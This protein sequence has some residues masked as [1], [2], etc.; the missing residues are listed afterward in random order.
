MLSYVLPAFVR[1][2]L[3]FIWVAV[4]SVLCASSAIVCGLLKYFFP[5][6]PWM[7]L[8]TRLMSALIIF[9]GDCMRFGVVLFTQTSVEVR[10]MEGLSKEK[11]YLI[12]ANH[13]SWADVLLIYQRFN[14]KISAIKVFMKSQLLW[15]PVIGWGCWLMGFP[16]LKRYTKEQLVK[17][18]SLK[19]KDIKS[20]KK[21]CRRA[22]QIPVTIMSFVEG[23]RYRDYKAKRQ[24]TPYQHLL[25]PRAGGV[26]YIMTAMED[27]LDQ[28][29]DVTLI[30]PAG[31]SGFWYYLCG[32]LPKVIIQVHPRP[33]TKAMIGDYAEDRDFRT[34]F[35]AWLNQLWLEKDNEIDQAIKAYAEVGKHDQDH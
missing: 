2:I 21:M 20:T 9:W 13:Q 26:A 23:T 10:G 15:L 25:K 14:H 1:G 3:H 29:L 27:M 4:F 18:P 28:V 24:K 32:T 31:K 34:H 5:V 6:K 16:F 33:I 30:Y 19:G 22:A 7:L 12:I 35:Q 17:N 11:N 8:M